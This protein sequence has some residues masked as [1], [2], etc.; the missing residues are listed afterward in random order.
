MTYVRLLWH[1]FLIRFL[2][3]Q[4]RKPETVNV[5]PQLK[6]NGW[7]SVEGFRFILYFYNKSGTAGKY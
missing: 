6:N 5:Y 1:G 3:V 4:R 2:V 7:I